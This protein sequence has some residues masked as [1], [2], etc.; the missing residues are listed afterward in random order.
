MTLGLALGQSDINNEERKEYFEVDEREFGIAPKP[1]APPPPQ[2]GRRPPPPQPEGRRPPPPQPEGYAGRNNEVR[3][4]FTV[5]NSTVGLASVPRP[6]SHGGMMPTV[7]EFIERVRGMPE[8]SEH[9]G[10]SIN[11]R[12][13]KLKPDVLYHDRLD[14]D[15]PILFSFL[16]TRRMKDFDCAVVG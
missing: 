2:E 4:S 14:L 6:N 1:V 13:Q 10:E 5:M 15:T 12:L 11:S 16:G 3:Q 8:Y 9:K 7:D